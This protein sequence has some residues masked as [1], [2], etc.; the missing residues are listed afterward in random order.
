[1]T[2]MM[3]KKKRGSRANYPVTHPQGVRM[4]EEKKDEEG[5]P[6]FSGFRVDQS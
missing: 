3:T 5:N 2:M 1:M 4:E 6:I